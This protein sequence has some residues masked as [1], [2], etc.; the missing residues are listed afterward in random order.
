MTMNRLLAIAVCAL[1]LSAGVAA[2]T[3]RCSGLEPT[4]AQRLTVRALLEGPY[5]DG[6]NPGVS[7]LVSCDGEAL[8]SFN[9][10]MANLEWRQPISSSTSFRVGSISKSLTAVAILQLVESGRVDLDRPISD[11][12]PLL[13]SYMRPVTVRQLMSHTSGLPDI[14][15]TPSLLPLARDWVDLRQVIG[16][17]GK[18]PPRG[19]PG[20]IFE[21]SNFNYVLLAALIESV[22]E[23]P[24]EAY[25]DRSYFEPLGLHRTRY[26]RRR[27][28]LP[29][30]AEGYE[31]SPFGELLHSENIDMSHASAAGALLSSAAD[32]GRWTHLLLSG[33]LL[34]PATLQAAWT[35]QELP[36]GTTSS[37]G[38]GFNLGEQFGHRVI[39]HT[40]LASGFQAAWSVY[41]EE[42][43]SVIVL[44][45][46]FHLPNPT[47]AMDRVAEI[48][49]SSP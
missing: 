4:E 39:W 9:S 24:Y 28:I 12:V 22:T 11:Y 18:T 27:S 10:G 49:L 17:Q 30:R 47:K 46:G 35:G 48:L 36:D 40:G 29:E 26:D 25:M 16:M 43:L 8:F 31:L 20:E 44:S 19:E 42:G 6:S 3:D 32:L 33:E 1:Q 38:L 2:A 21:Y 37:Y 34:E 7:V 13:P 45:N 5:P 23:T 14:L 15:L 41:P